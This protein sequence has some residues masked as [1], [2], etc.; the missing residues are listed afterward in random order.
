MDGDP[1][2]CYLES[3]KVETMFWFPSNDPQAIL[4]GEKS[5]ED[6]MNFFFCLIL[7]YD[8]EGNIN[9]MMN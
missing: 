8:L 6:E 1:L 7:W 5:L 4:H 9:V 2:G 3:N